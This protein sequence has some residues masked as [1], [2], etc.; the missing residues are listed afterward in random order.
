M[1]GTHGFNDLLMPGEKPYVNLIDAPEPAE[2][3][4]FV[5]ALGRNGKRL[6]I[7][8]AFVLGIALLVAILNGIVGAIGLVPF[9]LLCLLFQNTAKST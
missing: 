2:S 7:G 1:G 4:A 3:P 5:K 9:L 8:F 6:A